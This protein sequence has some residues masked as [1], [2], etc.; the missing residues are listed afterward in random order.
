MKRSIKLEI[1]LSLRALKIRAYSQV[2]ITVCVYQFRKLCKKLTVE[3]AM[4]QLPRQ[5]ETNR[6]PTQTIAEREAG[7]AQG[8]C[9]TEILRV[10]CIGCKANE[11]QECSW[12]YFLKTLSLYH[13]LLVVQ[14]YCYC[15]P[16]FLFFLNAKLIHV[17]ANNGGNRGVSEFGIIKCYCCLLV[18]STAGKACYDADEGQ[19]RHCCQVL[20]KTIVDLRWECR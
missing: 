15:V 1:D 7:W 12:G 5:T 13:S 6:H 3:F 16:F 8:T 2:F 17:F 9:Q 11:F 18:G 20:L 10:V 19:T 4:L 14:N